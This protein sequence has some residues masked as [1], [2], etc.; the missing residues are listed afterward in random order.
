MTA[1]IPLSGAAAYAAA[2]S[3]GGALDPAAAAKLLSFAELLAD[4]LQQPAALPPPQMPL[5]APAAVQLLY[6]WVAIP[7]VV[8]STRED[9]SGKKRP[10]PRWDRRP[11]ATPSPDGRVRP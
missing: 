5:P 3:G 7:V 10:P 4:E 6:P 1:I 8:P 9:R 2:V 11:G